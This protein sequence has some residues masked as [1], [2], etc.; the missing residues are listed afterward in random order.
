MHFTQAAVPHA[1]PARDPLH[2]IS[3]WTEN[4]ITLHGVSVF[5]RSHMLI[6][7]VWITHGA[8]NAIAAKLGVH[9]TTVTRWIVR[10]QLP[11]AVYQLLKIL[12]KGDL[13][14]MHDAWAGWSVDTKRGDLVTPVGECIRPG[15]VLSLPYRLHQLGTVQR[16]L[17]ECQRADAD[18]DRVY[19]NRAGEHADND[20]DAAAA[21]IVRP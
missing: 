18:R 21:Q 5:Y 8:A 19:Q 9:R 4:P 2:R 7:D 20:A 14:V 13:G 11:T 15:H 1:P 12:Q 16:Q 10:R 6:G 17:T 3:R